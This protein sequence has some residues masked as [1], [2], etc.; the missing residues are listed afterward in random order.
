M[1]ELQRFLDAAPTLRTCAV[2]FD[3]WRWN[4]TVSVINPVDNSGVDGMAVGDSLTFAVVAAIL[5]LR[6][7]EV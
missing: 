1:S 7:K 5:D 3:G 2:H 6:S 4:V